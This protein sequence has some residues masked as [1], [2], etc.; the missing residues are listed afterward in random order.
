MSVTYSVLGLVAALT[1]GLFGGMLQNPIVVGILVI[2]FLAL[3]LSMF[4]LYEIRIPQ[5]V[6]SFS[7]KSRR[8][9]LGTAMMGLTVGFIAAPCIGPFVLSL[10]VLVG[11]LKDAFLG[12]IMFFVLSMG[13]GFPFLFLA[14]FSGSISKLPR[15]G[16]WMEG[17]KV[18]FGFI[19]VG[20]AI[21][22]AQPLMPSNIYEIAFPL[23]LIFAGVY[24]IIIDR[25]AINTSTYTR[26]KY[27]IA[28][29]SI[30]WGSAGL[31]FGEK[32][33]ASGKF[34][35]NNLQTL[36]QI[37]SSIRNAGRPTIIDFYADWCA[38]CKELDKNTYSHPNVIAKSKEFNNIKVDLTQENAEIT[39]RFNIMGLPVVSFIGKDGKE[40]ENLRIT[41]FL[42]PD[43]FEKIMDKALK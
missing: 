32:H 18:I 38:Q 9:Y 17:V 26:I 39:K 31:E 43:E 19:M 21:Y 11:Q 36:A 10:L 37:D 20:L 1:G 30:V 33:I 3:A 24:L 15:S 34:E 29:A 12:F 7:G 28:I 41:G 8:G 22:T 42:K 14:F 16:E 6:A 27:T 4:G 5:S 40:I 2:I 23:Y 25:K 13:L 35:W